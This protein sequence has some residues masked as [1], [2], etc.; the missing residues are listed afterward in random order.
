LN[1]KLTYISGH[2]VRTTR[3]CDPKRAQRLERWQGHDAYVD[4][5]GTTTH[6]P[7]DCTRCR[8]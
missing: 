3:R 5:H 7:D 4:A 2:L 1:G 6:V 8:G